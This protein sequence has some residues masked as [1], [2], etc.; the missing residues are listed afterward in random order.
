MAEAAEDDAG[1]KF[2]LLALT[3]IE[4]EIGQAARH[5][6]EHLFGLDAGERGTQAEVDAEPEGQMP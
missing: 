3:E 6:R 2:G 1:L 5:G 4:P